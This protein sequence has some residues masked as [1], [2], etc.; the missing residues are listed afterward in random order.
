[1]GDTLMEEKK[2]TDEEI[3]KDFSELIGYETGGFDILPTT[4]NEKI[5]DLINRQKAEIERLTWTSNIQR[6][7]TRLYERRCEEL[8]KQVEKLTDKLQKVLLGIKADEVL[9][10]KGIEQAVKDTV[11]E[12]IEEI[13][14]VKEIFPNDTVG[15]EQVQGWCM[16]IYKLKE[17]AK[18]IIGG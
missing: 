13:D 15:Y 1:M 12:M 2:L 9:V 16:C 18:E 17:I 5:L 11:K 3:I 4:L 10:A 14:N 6:D 8:Q 7:G